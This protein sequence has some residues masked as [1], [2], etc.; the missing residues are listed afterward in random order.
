MMAIQKREIAVI[1]PKQGPVCQPSVPTTAV[2]A[3]QQRVWGRSGRRRD[4][5]DAILGATQRSNDTGSLNTII[6]K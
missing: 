5:A 6:G 4:E 1:D 2:R 3:L